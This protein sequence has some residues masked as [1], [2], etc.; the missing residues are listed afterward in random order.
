VTDVA[1]RGIDIPLLNNVINFHF[2]PV[3][4]LFI[5]RCGRAARQ[6]RIGYALS[7]VE[8]EELAYMVDVHS[9]LGNEIDTPGA[10][11]PKSILEQGD[12]DA[13]ED[14]AGES[15]ETAPRVREI[16]PY[17]LKTMTPSMVHTGLFPQDALDEQ[18][19]Y[20]KTVLSNDDGLA[21]LYRISENAMQQYR[22]TRSEATKEGVK[23]AKKIAKEGII[24]DIHPLIVGED[25]ARCSKAAIEKQHFVRMLQTFRPAQTVFETGIGTGT[26]SAAIKN[27]SKA[28]T[29]ESKGVEVM[30]ALRV[31]TAGALERNK[32]LR[33]EYFTK[34]AEESKK[35]KA[36]GEVEGDDDEGEVAE[37]GSDDDDEEDYEDD[38]NEY[39]M[40]DEYDVEEDEEKEKPRH[41]NAEDDDDYEQS[42]TQKRRMSAAEKRKLKKHGGSAASNDSHNSGMYEIEE[43]DSNNNNKKRAFTPGMKGQFR[44]DRF[45][46]AYGDEDEKAKFNEDILQPQS[47]LRSSEARGAVMLE[48]AML[49]I[50]PEDAVD[51]NKKRRMLRWDAKKRKFVKVRLVLYLL[52]VGVV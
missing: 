35:R 37:D 30:R 8:P 14:E 43:D 51:M 27:K 24:K 41:N 34:Q 49:D 13:A 18:N 9:L 44:D 17:T 19:D 3:A 4:K 11:L 5:H 52:I 33:A 6:G 32:A 1:A 45:F 20:L 7:L 42:I 31:V 26:A 22:R 12:E 46:M 48:S 23:R 10:P 50:M 16:E 38:D 21:M 36:E 25:P 39:I 15:Q 40:N 2:P 47:G 28:G 29:K